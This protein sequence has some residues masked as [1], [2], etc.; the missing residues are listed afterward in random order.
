MGWKIEVGRWETGGET[1]ERRLNLA[2]LG[3]PAAY[4][5]SVF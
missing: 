1:L 3:F 4:N 2:V 5:L